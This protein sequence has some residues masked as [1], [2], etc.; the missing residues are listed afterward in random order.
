MRV[1]PALV[2]LL[3]TAAIT[4]CGS[5]NSLTGKSVQTAV[6]QPVTV[7]NPQF[8]PAPG[9][10]STAQSVTISDATAGATIYY[11]TDGTQPTTSSQ[12]YTRPLTVSGS[13][14]IQ[15]MAALPQAT[16]S[17]V[18]VADYNIVPPVVSASTT[19]F[20]FGDD[21][22][23]SVITKTVA[24]IT[25]DGPTAASIAVTMSGDP[26]FALVAGQSCGSEVAANT[27]CPV[28]VA[29]DPTK[30]GVQTGA[31][32][33][34]FPTGTV[35]STTVSL[36]GTAGSIT[37][38]TVTPTNNPQVAAY[39][40]TPPFGATVSVQFG[41][42]TNYGFNTSTQ[43]TPIHG[44]PVNILV[45]GMLANTVYHMQATVTLE[46]G[47][48]YQDV[49]H[50]F[51][52]GA[53]PAGVTPAITVTQT[54]GLTPQSGI[55]LINTI[56][57]ASESAV[58]A[59]DLAGNVIWSYTAPDL[60]PGEFISAPRQLANGHILFVVGPN[61]NTYSNGLP[62]AGTVDFIREVDLAGNVV[63]QLSMD[64]LNARVT[65]GG[66]GNLNLE[67]FHHEVTP[68]PNGHTLILTNVIKPFTNLPGY[69]GT[70][71]VLGDVI[72][73]LDPDLNP[74]WV[75]NEFDHFDVNRHPM[76]FPDWTHTNA[77]TYSPD[78]GNILV[79][80][81]HQ[82]W[83]VKVN[84][85]DGL[86]DGSV[87]WKLGYQGDF[88]LQGGTEP[89][90]WFFAQ[91]NPAF[92]SAN[93]TGVFSL[94]VMDNG[95]DRAFADGTNC[96]TTGGADCYTTIPVMQVDENA[97]TATLTFHQVLPTNLY[98]IFAGSVDLLANNNVEYNL[99]GVKGPGGDSYIFE[100]TP[101][102]NPQTVW[103]MKLTGTNTYRA[104]RVPS[105]YP[106]V[107]W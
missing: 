89:Q 103:E 101:T 37:H 28:V 71:N 11:T 72:V 75:W 61:S 93:T 84:Y 86:G 38:G 99:A 104:F 92:F 59:T 14:V 87:I 79:S 58:L 3:S 44:G 12:Q 46:N 19:A 78:D 30:A 16:S 40:I 23:N 69:P 50:T 90:D 107:S 45:A 4:G 41:K 24:T 39:A 31:V 74:D 80:I 21:L 1:S 43:A 9:V 48:T 105:L 106:G 52:T 82:N 42:T 35:A 77:V 73:D 100:V 27:S 51:T 2:V 95:D 67:V 18:I 5:T 54:P 8:S 96:L 91:H 56:I 47:T 62:P 60:Q 65:A 6:A 66:F 17:G 98:N 70:T 32:Q 88:T 85:K 68:L 83:V 15:A 53:V 10:Y 33:V 102:Q 7:A 26:S 97:K 49:D 22:V 64:Q 34:Q 25:N 29:Y 20:D 63:R 57:G 94:A 55:E 76:G 36:T 81:R 13:Q